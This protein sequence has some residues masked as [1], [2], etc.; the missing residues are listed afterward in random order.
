MENTQTLTI[1]EKY[2]PKS[3]DELKIPHR[4]IEKI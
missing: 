3:L 4:E 1:L 2:N